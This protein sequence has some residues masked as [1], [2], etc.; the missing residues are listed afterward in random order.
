MFSAPAAELFATDPI[1]DYLRARRDT[2]RVVG[3]AFGQTE[4]PHDP[5]IGAAYGA[6]AFMV[7]RIRQ[8]GG[9]HGNELGRYQELY[10]KAE[11]PR[12]LANPNFWKLANLQYFYTDA[13]QPPIQE[14]TRLLGPVKNSA[15]STVYL[16]RFPGEQPAAWVTTAIMKAP[17]D[18]VLATVL[19][20]RFN[21]QTVAL[22]DTTAA[23][24]ARTDLR[25]PPAPL[26]LRATVTRPTPREIRIALDQPAPA[27]SALIVSE[28]YYPGWSAMVDGRPALAARADYS[29]IGVPLPAGA[30][31]VALRF[32][33]PAYETGK[34]V[35]LV[36]LTLAALALAAGAVLD[37]RR[38]V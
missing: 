21:L 37:R 17:D 25:V 26:A 27:G 9:Y 15:G 18:Q 22:F 8:V 1:V 23:V 34:L 33:S 7:H 4:A 36:A 14:M 29:L 28:N 16:Y 2:A 3:L 13:D 6:D 11:W 38:R 10:G 19:E 5:Y 32:A 20:P 12:Q 31:T 30:R 35:T 24:D